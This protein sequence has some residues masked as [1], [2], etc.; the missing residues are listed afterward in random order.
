M[1]I[2]TFVVVVVLNVLS[3]LGGDIGPELHLYMAR[4]ACS[5]EW[6]SLRRHLL[7]WTVDYVL[8]I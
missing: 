4:L 7:Q 1:N 8:E 5:Q 3:G 6:M 2:H